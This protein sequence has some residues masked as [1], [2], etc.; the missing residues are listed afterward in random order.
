MNPQK[1]DNGE[2]RADDQNI[3]VGH[4]QDTIRYTGVTEPEGRAFS[5]KQDQVGY[6]FPQPP[7]A[8]SFEAN[9]GSAH[10]VLNMAF[11][12]GSG[13]AIDFEVDPAVFFKF[14]GREDDGDAYP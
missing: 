11:C 10:S 2:D 13:R 6:D 8:S 5:P 3:F 7:A 14:G 9:F 12:D 1:Y 4:D